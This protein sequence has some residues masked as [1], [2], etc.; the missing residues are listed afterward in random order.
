VILDD[1]EI[2]VALLT[3]VLAPSYDFVVGCN[4]NEG[5]RLCRS[6]R[7]DM[8]I[9]DIGMPELDG[10]QMLAEFQKDPA[11]ASIPVLVATATHFSRRSREELK[12]FPQVRDVICK[13]FDVDVVA[14]AIARILDEPGSGKKS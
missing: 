4:G 13:P 7:V 10:I 2:F 8:L 9:T 5:L 11:L 6:G 3:A 12:R 14:K 1:D